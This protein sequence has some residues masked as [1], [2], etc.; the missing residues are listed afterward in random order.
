MMNDDCFEMFMIF[1]IILLCISIFLRLSNDIAA[2]GFV[3]AGEFQLL[4]LSEFKKS[5][6]LFNY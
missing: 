1:L 5:F 3:G 4:I 6:P 2:K